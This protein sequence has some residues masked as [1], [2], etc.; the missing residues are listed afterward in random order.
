MHKAIEWFL[1][2]RNNLVLNGVLVT[3]AS[4]TGAFGLFGPTMEQSIAGKYFWTNPVE[5]RAHLFFGIVFVITGLFLPL[6][7]QRYVIMFIVVIQLIVVYFALSGSGVDGMPFLGT[8]NQNPADAL[9]HLLPAIVFMIIL[10]RTR[11]AA[12]ADL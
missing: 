4:I 10:H 3:L 9:F 8:A 12:K 6:R 7:F 2:I 1:D 11:L 5:N